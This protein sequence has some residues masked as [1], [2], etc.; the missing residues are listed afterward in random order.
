MAID[1]TGIDSLNAGAPDLRL[2][3]N[4]MA[5]GPYNLGSDRKNAAAV[6]Q[7]MDEGDKSIYNFNFE[8][9]LQSGDWMDQI[10]GSLQTGDRQMAS[11]PHPDENW[12]ALWQDLREKGE[13]PESIRNLQ[14]FK[15]WF[16]NQDFDIDMSQ[17]NRSGIMQAAYG[18]T[19]RP[20]YTQSRKQR[21]AGGGITRLGY[22]QG[23]SVQ[24]G[25]KNYLGDQEM[26]NAPKK[27]QSGP[28]KPDTELA[29]ITNAEKDLILK[30][31]LHGSLGGGPNLGP[32]GVMSLDSWG[33]IS[34]GQAGSDVSRDTDRGGGGGGD[35]ST[36]YSYSAP[37]PAPA[38]AAAG[39]DF[40]TN[41]AAIS[42][43][44]S[45][46]MVGDTSLAGLPQ[47]AGES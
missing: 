36:T 29:Y 21:M 38:P 44:Q 22:N 32:S 19:A 3:G 10:Q 27:W 42:P 20:T 2:T 9:F 8:F 30:A 45:V 5:G 1:R 31:D 40:D 6:W 16:H 15:N 35:A 12:D 39:H 17:R 13:V 33:D 43:G 28:G 41:Y 47:S 26:V 11:A 24:G 25:V 23:Y 34:G 14:E 7:N 37:A 4:K 18:G 46:A